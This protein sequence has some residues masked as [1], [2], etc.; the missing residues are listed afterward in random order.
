MRHLARKRFGQHFLSDQGVI[1]E[2]IKALLPKPNQH[3][4]EIGPG[5]GALSIPLLKQIKY[6]EVIELDRDL[7]PELKRRSEHIQGELIIY[8]ADALAFDFS[9]LKTDDRLLRIFGNLPYNISTPL[10]FHLLQFSPLIEDMFFML[11]KE[12]ACRL[13]ADC[14]TEEYGRLSVMVQYHCRVELLF[15]VK[16]DAFYPPPQVRSSMVRLTPYRDYPFRA[17][18]YAL[19]ERIVR[20]AFGQ[21]RKTLRNSLKGII[22]DDVW[23]TISIQSDLRAENL[24]VKDFVEIC[25]AL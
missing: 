3:L 5:Q 19:F 13:A 23:S 1:H 21:R 7:I 10:I 11:Q 25:N 17:K 14:D 4:V 20:H 24:S 12:V 16:A 6:L 15:D 18:N 22:P 2:I 8:E 9:T